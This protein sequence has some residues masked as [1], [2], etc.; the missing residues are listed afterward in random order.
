MGS[1]EWVTFQGPDSRAS[2]G[3]KSVGEG[4]VEARDEGT[5]RVSILVC[6]LVGGEWV[7]DVRRVVVL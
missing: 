4:I 6:G 5:R 1:V 3:G 2:E 7:N